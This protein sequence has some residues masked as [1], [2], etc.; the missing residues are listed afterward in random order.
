MILL[1]NPTSQET[2]LH[3]TGGCWYTFTVRDSSGAIWH[4]ETL[5]GCDPD[6]NGFENTTSIET[7]VAGGSRN[8]PVSWNQLDLSGNRALTPHSYTLSWS[9]N[10]LETV[11]GAS[12]TITLT[13]Q[14]QNP[15]DTLVHSVLKTLVFLQ[16]LILYPVFL[17]SGIPLWRDRVYKTS[18]KST[19]F[20]L[21]VP[22]IV[23]V[24]VAAV[25]LFS[26]VDQLVCVSID[27]AGTISLATQASQYSWI[28]PAA[29]AVLL[30]VGGRVDGKVLGFLWGGF[31]AASVA[32]YL[33]SYT[34]IQSA[35]NLYEHL[36]YSNWA[37]TWPAYALLFASVPANFL[38]YRLLLRKYLIHDR[39]KAEDQTGPPQYP[40]PR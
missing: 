31:E 12:T 14:S 35:W 30:F 3:F 9:L 19:R 13:G 5:P 2:V 33:V 6:F 10:S 36:Y 25:F 1:Y 23:A 24:I 7:I 27:C 18:K 22:A 28:P 8:I 26:H 39:K 20:L 40:A 17:V 29:W 37:I 15:L 11:P 4:N 38:A 34:I 21:A 32:A 16:Y